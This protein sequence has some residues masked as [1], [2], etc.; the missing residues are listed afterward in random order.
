MTPEWRRAIRLRNRLWKKYTRQHSESSWSDYKKQRNVCT[1]LR[2]KA[3]G[4]YFQS[5]AHDSVT[6]PKKF[7]KFFGPIFRTK[8]SHSNDINLIEDNN[9][10]GDKQQIASVFNDY[11]VNI[12][13]NVH[14]LKNDLFSNGFCDH[15]SIFH[16]KSFMQNNDCSDNF[17]FKPT[18]R[19][20]VMG[21]IQELS[22]SKA[23]GYDNIPVRLVKDGAGIIAD[24]LAKL[25]NISISSGGYPTLWKYGQVTPVFK[26]GDENLKSNYRP[27]T[28]LVSFNNIFERI[29][30]IQ[31]CGYFQDKLS[32]YLSAYRKYHSCQTALLRL[33]EELRTALDSK[34]HAAMVGIDLSKAFD[35]LPHELLL[36]K[37]KAYGL[38]ENS[39]KLLASYLGNRFQR[40]K[41][42]D[43]YSSWLSLCKGVPQG[44][45]LGPLLFNIFLNDLL[46]L[47]T[48]SNINSYAD[49]T[50]LFLH[51]LNPT[52]TQTLLQSDLTLVSDWFQANGMTTNPSKCLSMWFGTNANDLSV[53]LNGIIIDAVNTMQLLGVSIDRDL[54]FNVHVKETI[55]KVSCKLQVL[56]RYKHFI[57]IYAKKRLY[58]A[59]FLPYLTYCSTVWFHC[60]KRN[61]DKIEK[62]NESI[63][64]FVFNDFNSSYEKLLQEINQPSLRARRINDMLILVFLALN[65]A[66]PSYISRLFTERQT[67][68]GLR[69][70][71]RLVIPRVN[72]TNYGLHSFRYHASKL[73]N[74]LPDNV[75][76]STSLAAFK[77]ALRT[78]HLQNECCSFCD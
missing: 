14:E 48:K 1:S 32:P 54:N 33:L 15:P 2:R 74:L 20:V 30:S 57:P 61:A 35:C 38:S 64:R 53:S 6:K 39:V 73:W 77:N 40:V 49:D 76:V 29:L 22:S 69:G 47:T 36:S 59:Y 31:L 28:V 65:D 9:F 21:V 60:G 50:Q 7:W 27:I 71:R 45:V 37:L 18:N 11:F 13:S 3:I 68:I 43:T 25:F 23:A 10:L 42:G 41:I 66:A 19:V 75:R 12:A 24:P 26:K 46:F 58:L 5:K 55:R 4:C 51:G 67:N 56:K 8:H 34:E 17:S 62:L 52:T 16:I 72:T 70:K 78:V 63:L 44:S